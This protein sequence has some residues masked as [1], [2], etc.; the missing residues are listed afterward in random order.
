MSKPKHFLRKA[1]VAVRYSVT[2][3]TIER[4]SSPHDGR[5]PAPKYRG[6]IP[7][8]DE[9]ELDASDRAAATRP[10]PRAPKASADLETTDA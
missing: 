5:I 9:D 2:P 3:R 6:K 1:A 8:W 7:L 10:R 4:W